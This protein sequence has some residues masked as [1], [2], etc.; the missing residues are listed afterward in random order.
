MKDLT[1]QRFGKLVALRP[2]DERE[3]RHV[4]WECLCDC[5]NHA[6]VQQTYLTGG[7]TVSC[8]CLRK[9]RVTNQEASDLSGKRFGRF[10]ARRPMEE[11]RSGQVVW[12]CQCDCGEIAYVLKRNLLK[13]NTKSCGCLFK[14][15]AVQS[16]MKDLTGKR[17]GKLVV[18]G[19][20]EMRKQ[21]CIVWKCQCD[22]GNTAFVPSSL[23]TNGNTASCGCLKKTY[24]AE[25]LIKDL[26]GQ[27]FGALVAL[28]PTEERINRQVVWECQCDCGNTV[29]VKSSDLKQGKMTSCGC[30]RKRRVKDIRDLTGLRFGKLVAV[31]PTEERRNGFVMWECLCDCGNTTFVRSSH[32]KNGGILSCGCLRKETIKEE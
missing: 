8:G 17:F 19:P 26:T 21:S 5:G 22:C 18:V 32:L 6:F 12:E 27:R 23:L 24:V 10:V 20:T 3:N 28:T 25:K 4:I 11:Q 30:L 16:H 2:T 15:A 13:G 14:E 1:G 7:R 29:L 31:R 9:E